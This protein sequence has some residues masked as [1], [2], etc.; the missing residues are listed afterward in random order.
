MRWQWILN[1]GITQKLALLICPPIIGALIGGSLLIKEEWES[2]QNLHSLVQLT[3]LAETNS[4]LVHQ[5]QKERGMSAGFISSGGVS[6]KLKL[7]S[8]R[9]L[10]NKEIQK[11]KQKIINTHYSSSIDSGLNQLERELSELNSIRQSVDTLNIS[12]KDQVAYY[13]EINKQLLSVVDV[14]AKQAQDHTISIEVAAF[15]AYLQMKERAGIERAVLSTTFGKSN[16]PSHKFAKFINL[17]AEQQSFENRFFALSS[18]KNITRYQNQVLSSEAVSTVEHLRN[19]VRDMNIDQIETTTTESWFKV[20]TS[21]IELLRKFELH[22]SSQIIDLTKVKL[23]SA[24]MFLIFG[25][26][27]LSVLVLIIFVLTLSIAGYLRSNIKFLSKSIARAG[28]ELDLSIRIDNSAKD[29]LGELSKAFNCMM[30]EFEKVILNTKESSVLIANTVEHIN[31]ASEEMQS[32]VLKGQSQ[33][34]QVAAAM[35]ELSATVSQIASNAADA[36]HASSE[37]AQE[38]REGNTEVEK[39]DK[40]IHDLSAEMNAASSAINNLDKEIHGIVGVLDV[41]SGIAEQTNLLALNA[42]IEAARA[43]ETGRG[44]AVVADEVRSLAQRA[45]ASTADIKNMTDRLQSGAEEAVQAMSRGLE[46]AHES[47]SEVQTAGEDLNRIVQFVSTIDDMNVQIATATDQQSAV[48]EEVS[49]NATEIN[50]LYS[51][52]SN[53]AGKISQLNSELAEASEQLDNRVKQFN[54]SI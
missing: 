38:A 20:A 36:A 35:T 22:L 46:K 10:V 29:E 49:N 9:Q 52:S 44:F 37:A 14:I 17:V 5:L 1:L 39:T 31:L 24:E 6:F 21:R 34:E 27:A 11:L 42:A 40:S 30:T 50:E 3:E 53:I 26:L 45:K 51:N 28:N 8:Q 7:V 48:T 16:I 18:K 23:K 47:V 25:S 12:L 54:L 19:V 41:I 43:G 2:Y 13:T 32:D 4:N 33:A 15:G